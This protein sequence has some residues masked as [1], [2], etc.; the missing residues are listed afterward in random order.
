MSRHSAAPGLA[1]TRG[2]ELSQI[3]AEPSTT[4]MSLRVFLRTP[5]PT[6]RK[7]IL[8]PDE[9]DNLVGYILSMKPA[10]PLR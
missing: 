10:R 8:G 7:L 1:G 9:L 6:M 3:A 5:H 2:A 4:G